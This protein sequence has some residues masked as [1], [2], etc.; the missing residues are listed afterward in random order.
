MSFFFDALNKSAN[1]DKHIEKYR[2]ISHLMA[3]ACESYTHYFEQRHKGNYI[4][5]C[6]GDLKATNLWICPKKS[7]FFGL[8]K[9]PQQLIALDCVDFN[10]D[11]CH[12]DTLSDVAMLAIDLEMHLSDCSDQDMNTH[13]GQKLPKHFLFTYLRAAQENSEVAWPLLEYY[14]TEKAMVCAYVSILYDKLPDHGEK[15]LNIAL[16]HAQRLKKMLKQPDPQLL[17]R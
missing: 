13:C 5:R 7:Y 17:L 16:I 2:W 12:I 4:K 15:Y 3:Q 11:F 1:G 14:M 8:T 6:H 10:P 9:S